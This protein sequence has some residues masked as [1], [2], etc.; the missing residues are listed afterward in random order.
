MKII[1]CFIFY[2][3]LDL[4]LYRLSILY[5]IVDY[6]VLVESSHTFSG[7]EKS[8]YYKDNIKL[9]EKFNKKIIHIIIEPPFKYPNINYDNKEQWE[10]EK[11]QRNCIMDGIN[12]INNKEIIEDNDI[13]IITDVDEI[14]DIVLLNKIKYV[15]YKLDD[16]YSLELEL[17]YYNLNTY[18]GKWFYAKI[19]P[20]KMIK[21]TNYTIEIIRQMNTK[22]CIIN[23][24]WHLSYFFD[25]FYIQNKISNF[26]HQEYNNNKYLDLETIQYKIN[27]QLDLF[28]RENKCINIPI[29]DNKYLPPQYNIYFKNFIFN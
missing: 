20:Y 17:Y 7:K 3:E 11:Y 14:P 6:F 27:N 4:L 23:A 16:I 2:N 25:K 15:N 12:I 28:D 19:L 5:D 29:K 9:F 18:M 22:K 26:S 8:L 1:D 21:N 24:G 10:N 13:I